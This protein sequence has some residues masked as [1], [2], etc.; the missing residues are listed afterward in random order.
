[1]VEYG[2]FSH[3][4]DYDIIFTEILNLVAHSNSIIGSKVMAILLNG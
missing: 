1:M 4:I 2:A 3:K